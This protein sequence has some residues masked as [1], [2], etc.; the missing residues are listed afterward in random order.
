MIPD[1]APPP[2]TPPTKSYN[3]PTEPP[4]YVTPPEGWKIEGPPM[5]QE[6]GR[7]TLVRNYAESL[8]VGH[9]TVFINTVMVVFSLLMGAQTD[10]M[11]FHH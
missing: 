10:S 2:Y 3:F 4:G 7:V 6:D 9:P 11:H 1:E 8:R 5:Y